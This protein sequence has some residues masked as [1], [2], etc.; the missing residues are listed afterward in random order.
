VLIKKG[1]VYIWKPVL[2]LCLV[3]VCVVD[4]CWMCENWGKGGQ[5][6][7][8]YIQFQ[9]PD[10]Q[11]NGKGYH[12]WQWNM[13][14]QSPLGR[15]EGD[16]DKGYHKA[17]QGPTRKIQV[18]TTQQNSTD[19]ESKGPETIHGSEIHKPRDSP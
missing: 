15:P 13:W 18:A 11:P 6:Y 14:D 16:V 4:A 8:F 10:D 12:L 7:F 19:Q 9:T 5:H 17:E 3:Y 1:G 2:R